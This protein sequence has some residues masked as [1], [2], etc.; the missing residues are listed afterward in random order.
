MSELTYSKAGDYLIPDLTIGDEPQPTYGKYGM[1]RKRWMKEHRKGTYSQLLLSGKLNRH[2]A[3][4]DMLAHD[5]ISRLVKEMAAWQG[6][7]EAL[8]ARDQMAW[9]GTMNMIK[10]QAEEIVIAKYV[11]A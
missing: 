11:Y 9:V 2:I 10:A 8:K 3:E 1:L 5:F 6:V 7:D 4:T